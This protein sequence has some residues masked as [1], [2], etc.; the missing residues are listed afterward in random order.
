MEVSEDGSQP[1]SKWQY[2]DPGYDSDDDYHVDE[3]P[4]DYAHHF[5][6]NS[7]SGLAAASLPET[8]SRSVVVEGGDVVISLSPLEQVT[9]ITTST[10]LE[11]SSPFWRASLSKYWAHNKTVGDQ[12]PKRFELEFKTPTDASLVGK[13]SGFKLAWHRTLLTVIALD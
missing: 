9:V 13:V 1:Y 8:G 3:D 5:K 11:Q 7:S 6:I 10:V 12:K 4:V 2:N